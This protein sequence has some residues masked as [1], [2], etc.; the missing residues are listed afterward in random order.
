MD[1]LPLQEVNDKLNKVKE[2]ELLNDVEIVRTITFLNFREALKFV[3][4]VG[5]LAEAMDHHP[6]IL[7]H[8]WNNVT[9]TLSTHSAGGI[10]E[11]D[12]NLALQVDKIVKN[13]E[14]E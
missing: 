9:L 10:T 8:S 14:N 13:Y 2:W 1:V 12:F 6:D 3:N 5:D 7:M 4:E 11:N